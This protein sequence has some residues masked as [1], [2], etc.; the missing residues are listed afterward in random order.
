VYAQLFA[1]CLFA[2]FLFFSYI[3][4]TAIALKSSRWHIRVET[5]DTGE[6]DCG[7]V[8]LPLY[9]VVNSERAVLCRFS[10]T[11]LTGFLVYRPLSVGSSDAP[12]K[13]RRCLRRPIGAKSRYSAFGHALL[14]PR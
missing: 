13:S 14:M 11:A 8:G 1:E 5:R 10:S 6:G 9:A 12:R 7:K 3:A 4:I 2:T